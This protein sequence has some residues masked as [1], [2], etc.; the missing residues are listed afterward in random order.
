[1]DEKTTKSFVPPDTPL[2]K[3][4]AYLAFLFMMACSGICALGVFLLNQTIYVA[5]WSAILVGLCV[6]TATL[7]QAQFGEENGFRKMKWKD[8]PYRYW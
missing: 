4:R 3:V 5:G 7:F 8:R 6:F 1:M 2:Y